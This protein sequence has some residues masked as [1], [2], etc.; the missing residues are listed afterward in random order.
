VKL[1]PTS[2]EWNIDQYQ[3]TLLTA[4]LVLSHTAHHVIYTRLNPHHLTSLAFSDVAS[5]IDL[6][7]ATGGGG[8]GSGDGGA[9][10]LYGHPLRRS[11]SGR[12]TG[13]AW[14]GRYCSLVIGRHLTQDTLPGLTDRITPEPLIQFTIHPLAPIIRSLYHLSMNFPPS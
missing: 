13:Q 5:I 7:L 3:S 9:D 11:R 12:V 2:I 8:G 4:S 14:P 1:L 6:T 10:F